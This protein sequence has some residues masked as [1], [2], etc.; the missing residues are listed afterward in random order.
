MSD[1]TDTKQKFDPWT[2]PDP[3]PEDVE[4]W[5]ADPENEW[6]TVT[7]PANTE[8]WVLIPDGVSVEEWAERKT[9]ARARGEKLPEHI[10]A[11]E[12]LAKRREAEEKDWSPEQKAKR[13]E[14]RRVALEALEKLRR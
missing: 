1:V 12:E 13:A 4:A 2:D 5:F 14:E 6:V 8:V 3:Q 9:A 7:V 10:A 11:E